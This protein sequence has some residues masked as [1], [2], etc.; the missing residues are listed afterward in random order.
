MSS[1][2]SPE[3]AQHLADLARLEITPAEVA[4]LQLDTVL[5]YV[6]R[7]QSLDTT[8]VKPFSEHHRISREPRADEAEQFDHSAELLAG[9]VTDSGLLSVKPI[10]NHED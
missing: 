9:H 5:D 1:H 7:I 4:G 2:I 10:F 3:E 6:E 8:G